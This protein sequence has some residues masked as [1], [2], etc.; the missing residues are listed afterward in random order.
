[1]RGRQKGEWTV[2]QKEYRCE[3]VPLEQKGYRYVGISLE[4]ANSLIEAYVSKQR[5]TETVSLLEVQGRVIARDCISPI[6]QPPFPRSPLDG[7]AARA[8][9][10]KGASREKPAELAVIRE[11]DAGNQPGGPIRVG[12]A[13]RI[14]TGA[15]IPEGANCIIRQEVTDYGEKTVHIY[16][17]HWTF[18]NYCCAG[19]DFRQGDCLIQKGIRAGAIEMGIL[20]SMG[21]TEVP[22]Y[23]RPR[24][25]VFTTGDELT[26]PGEPLM[27][28]KIY[29]SNMYVVIGR[30]KELGAEPV[31]AQIVPDTAEGVAQV[32]KE[33]LPK[34][35]LI[36]T[37]GGVS[38]GKKDIMHRAL[39]VLGADK[40][41][42]KVLVKPGT[43]TVFSMAEGTPIFSL[44]GNPFG[45]LTHLEL[46]VRPVLKRMAGEA[47][48]CLKEREAVMGNGFS[49]GS[50][51]RRF[52]RGYYE[53]GTVILPEGSHSSGVL[54]TMQGCNC[55][56]DIPA[57]SGGL[58]EGDRVKV[59]I[60]NDK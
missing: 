19:E 36:L 21:C 17:E 5:D 42:W 13:V 12:E 40:I 50:S 54:G 51:M 49:K 3:G 34:T 46:L 24:V 44:S 7:Y 16:Q 57:D 38:V 32:L 8:E 53:D 22:V 37:T 33:A 39:Y 43:P 11:I 47:N 4:Q 31:L 15:P 55:L 23:R 60:V 30:L 41:F 25:A 29:N 28:G 59:V 2:E 10:T 14:M 45:A 1:M 35:D 26:A 20:A 9:D 18:E 48:S 58:S 27:P 52:V 56:I 6:S